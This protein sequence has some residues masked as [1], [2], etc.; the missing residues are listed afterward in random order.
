MIKPYEVTSLPPGVVF[1]VYEPSSGYDPNHL[2]GC[3]SG[4]EIDRLEKL[5]YSGWSIVP[6]PVQF[7]SL[8]EK[9][10]NDLGWYRR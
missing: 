7:H 6:G 2:V 3:L 9:L 10:M 1:I 8:D 5:G 4:E